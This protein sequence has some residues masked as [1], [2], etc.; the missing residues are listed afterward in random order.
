MWRRKD[1]EEKENGGGGGEVK[2]GEVEGDEGEVLMVR[3]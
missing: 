1:K 2:E 3:I